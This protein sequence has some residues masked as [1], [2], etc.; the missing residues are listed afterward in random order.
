VGCECGV[1]ALVSWTQAF[2]FCN[3]GSVRERTGR[4]QA[5]VLENS[6]SGRE[7]WRTQAG[8]KPGRKYMA[9]TLV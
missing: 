4:A 9:R 1:Q 6:G 3:S 5:W 8:S 7:T 2:K